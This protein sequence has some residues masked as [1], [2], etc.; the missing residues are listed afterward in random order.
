M[1]LKGR[2]A[3]VTGGGRGNGASMAKGLA[4]EGASVAVIDI[5]LEPAEE[6]A[7]EIRQAGGTAT[8]FELDV[9]DFEACKATAPRV[10]KE[11][12]EVSILVNNAGVI[13]RAKLDDPDIREAWDLCMDVNTGGVFNATMGFLPHLRATKG[14]IINIAS[15]VA[16]VSMDTFVGYAA[17]KSALL[18]LT[19]NFARQLAPEGVRV[20]AIAP[21]PFETPMTQATMADKERQEFYRSKIPLGRWGR[22]DELMGP[23]VFLASDMSSFVTGTTVVVDG[24]VLIG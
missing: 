20:N 8:A 6:I 10:A 15:V 7:A 16:F 23:I 5:D 17:S 3:L 9:T 14:S 4:R 13:R 2:V 24:G 1:M 18:G 21:G 11:L 19:R 12:G 22:P